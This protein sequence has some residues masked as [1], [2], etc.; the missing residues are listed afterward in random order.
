LTTSRKGVS[1]IRE[2]RP[3]YGRAAG[4]SGA[5]CMATANA[6]EPDVTTDQTQEEE[7]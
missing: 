6:E 3:T 1:F 5:I 4:G 7:S 2:I